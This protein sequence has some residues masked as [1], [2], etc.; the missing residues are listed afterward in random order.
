VSI[1]PFSAASFA[2]LE[3]LPE[4]TPYLSAFEAVIVRGRTVSI[5]VAAGGRSTLT[6]GE[7]DTL[8]RD[9]RAR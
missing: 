6:A 5:R 4:L 2:L 1:E 3:K 9:F 7:F 8:V